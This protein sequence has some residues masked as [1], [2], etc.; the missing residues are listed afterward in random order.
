MIRTSR[1]SSSSSSIKSR[2]NSSSV[3][4]LKEKER[5]QSEV[6]DE[7]QEVLNQNKI[8]LE[9]RDQETAHLASA[10]SLWI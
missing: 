5:K 3:S 6:I 2:K 1:S 10:V 7:L 8:A 9:S 4:T